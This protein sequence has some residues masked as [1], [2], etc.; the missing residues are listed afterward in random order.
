[1]DECVYVITNR[2]LRGLVKVGFSTRD[3]GTRA[4]ELDHTGVPHPYVVAFAVQVENGRLVEREAHRH[5]SSYSEGKEWFRCSVGVAVDAIRS[6]CAGAQYLELSSV[7]AEAS[8]RAS[9]SPLVPGHALRDYFPSTSSSGR[10]EQG[11]RG[12]SPFP[13]GHPLHDFY[14]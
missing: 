7:N 3:A 5:L 14:K 10:K 9:G 8:G 6:A 4:A 11:S 1:M 13:P 2:A 12:G